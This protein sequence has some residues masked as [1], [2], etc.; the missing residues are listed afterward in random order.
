LAPI[1]DVASILPYAPQVQFQ[2]VKLAMKIGGE[3]RLSE[4]GLRHWGRFS[5]ENRIDFDQVR[6]RIV[7]MA[8]Q[9]P[10]LA[11]AVRN[12]IADGGAAHSLNDKLAAVFAD[13]AK[14]VKGQL[15]RASEAG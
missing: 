3:Y 5:D 10:D 13:R 7:V 1:Y 15:A 4:I 6:A 11:D 9:L 14:W 8:D 2:D 12:Q